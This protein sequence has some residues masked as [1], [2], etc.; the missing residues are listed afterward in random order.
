MDRADQPDPDRTGI[1]DAA[2]CDSRPGHDWCRP[3]HRG[4]QRGDKRRPVARQT[5]GRDGHQTLTI[6]HLPFYIFRLSSLE[7]QPDKMTN[8]KSKMANG[9][10]HLL[11]HS[12]LELR[13]QFG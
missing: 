2:E 9:R 12:D 6:F 8:G 1:L 5:L 3:H 13:T 11:E 7:H 10:W 4:G